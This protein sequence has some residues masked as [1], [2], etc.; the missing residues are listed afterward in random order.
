MPV[1][2][3]ASAPISLAVALVA[4]LVAFSACG[5]S[6]DDPVN[7][8]TPCS[9]AAVRTCGCPGGSEGTQQCAADGRSYEACECG[10][11]AGG[12]GGV[13]GAGG[14]AG[15]GT[16]GGSGAGGVQ[17]DAGSD[18]SAGAA[19]GGA[20]G[21]GPDAGGSGSTVVI[22]EL[23]P[24]PSPWELALAEPYLVASTS[25][26]DIARIA[27]GT[28]TSTNL[29]T[30]QLVMDALSADVD[31]VFFVDV[32]GTL[33]RVPMSG[34]AVGTVA[35]L[36]R[37]GPYCTYPLGGNI[38][39]GGQGGIA[40]LDL[41][42]NATDAATVA[43]TVAE[44]TSTPNGVYFVEEEG[45][46]WV[47]DGGGGT[48][49]QLAAGTGKTRA[50]A[51]HGDVIYWNDDLA[52]GIVKTST[53]GAAL[54]VIP[55]DHPVR[56]VEAGSGHVFWLVASTAPGGTFQPDGRLERFDVATEQVDVLADGLTNPRDL[57]VDAANTA[58]VAVHDENV[59][60]KVTSP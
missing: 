38:L 37:S 43:G 42:G 19:G 44:I 30:G 6:S 9:P 18:A 8:P 49:A 20:G 16:A 23:S 34:G 27:L 29:T 39:V 52:G 7:G 33:R 15:K 17:M 35:N 31:N 28:G 53:A 32:V 54:G 10:P 45:R 24:V 41:A 56:S 60:L 12:T 22:S 5:S 55:V 51:A 4:A 36:V 59:V 11:G 13:V 14:T 26:G 50:L 2:R 3:P 21:S 40:S 25:D 57:V 47:L 48:P 46:L 58:Y 1:D